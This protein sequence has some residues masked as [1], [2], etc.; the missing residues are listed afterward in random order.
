[1]TTSLG[2]TA[3]RSQLFQYQVLTSIQFRYVPYNIR[4]PVRMAHPNHIPN[5][6]FSQFLFISIYFHFIN[7]YN[8]YP[9]QQK[10]LSRKAEKA[11]CYALE[12]RENQKKSDPNKQKPLVSNNI[13]KTRDQKIKMRR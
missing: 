10:C 8:L 12:H 5:S 4:F 3:S 11:L 2:N 13:A 7:I 1:M 6:K 9:A